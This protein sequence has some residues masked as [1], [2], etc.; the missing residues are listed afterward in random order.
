MLLS[1]YNMLRLHVCARGCGDADA[2]I[3]GLSSE[4]GFPKLLPAIVILSLTT[5]LLFWREEERGVSHCFTLSPEAANATSQ[6]DGNKS[7]QSWCSSCFC[8]CSIIVESLANRTGPMARAFDAA[9][10]VPLARGVGR[11]ETKRD[12][13]LTRPPST[14]A[15]S[16]VHAMMSD[17]KREGVGHSRER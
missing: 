3:Q 17:R 14:S 15:M 10:S 11:A 9:Q 12:A 8:M 6:W 2:F 4:T 13:S 1:S 5:L 7:A 16:I